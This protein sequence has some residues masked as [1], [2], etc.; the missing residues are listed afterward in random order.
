MTRKDFLLLADLLRRGRPPLPWTGTRAF[1]YEGWENAVHEVAAGLAEQTN[2]FDVELFKKNAG[3]ITRSLEET[4]ESIK[5]A[6][7]ERR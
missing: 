6:L 2:K 4:S 5:K 3:V 1:V 7:G